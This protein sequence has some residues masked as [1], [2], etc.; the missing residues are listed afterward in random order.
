MRRW[1][2]WASLAVAIFASCIST[3]AQEEKKKEPPAVTSYNVGYRILDFKYKD[4]SSQEKTLTTA[5]WYPTDAEEKDY[6]YGGGYAKGKVAL[7]APVSKKGVPY[8][9]VLYSHGYS[10]SGVAAVFLTE[11]L[12]RSGFVVVAPDHNDDLSAVRIRGGADANLPKIWE[13]ALKIAR[14]E[15]SFDHKKFEY[16]L[17]E[18]RFA[19]DKIL[20][21]SKEEN[22]P[23]SGMIDEKRIAIAGHSLGSYTALGVT[24]MREKDER[25]KAAVYFSGGL[26]WDEK[27]FSKIKI[28]AM[29]MYGETETYGRGILGL[30]D[31]SVKTI[32][33]YLWCDG[34]RFCLEVKH[35]THMTF[36]ERVFKENTP[37]IAKEQ[38]RLIKEYTTAFLLKY[39]NNEPKADDVLSRKDKMLTRYYYDFGIR[40]EVETKK[41]IAYYEGEDA[42]A[43]KH[44]LDIYIPKGA[45]SFKVVMFVHGGAWCMGDKDQFLLPYD[46]V[47]KAFAQ[48]GIGT[49]VINY[50]LTPQVV[51]PG[52][53]KDVA[54]AFAWIYKN[55]EKEGGNKERLFV[56]GHS[57]GGH[58]VALLGT[59]EKYLKE[60]ELD[61]KALAGVIPISGVFKIE[62][63]LLGAFGNDKENWKDASPIDNVKENL[64]PFLLLY[65]S[66]D[67]PG[68]SSMAK[69]F[70]D[71]LKAKKNEFRLLEIADKT[72]ITV[73]TS[74]GKKGDRTTEE[75]VQFI[76][77]R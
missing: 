52:H 73:I 37:E 10:G 71:A 48:R 14:S 64:P 15:K 12:A 53:I 54:R 24:G 26:F 44:K 30:S 50:R 4:E 8:P 2:L 31:L 43:V 6:E 57:A 16:R 58:L 29:F 17:K 40:Y 62:S 61:F 36:C 66:S 46:Y 34:P 27:E 67:I 70:A 28:P 68:L 35:G 75:I 20:E 72:H 33:A 47:G 1:N 18:I 59:N 3:F 63:N 7:D 32:G 69:S 51:H 39:L 41:N 76:Q 42:D 49:V 22:S 21:L 65:A 25:F 9:L 74:I 60:Q 45:K 55:I 38:V 13:N 11:Y 23:F 5:V 56:C 19:C 77:Q